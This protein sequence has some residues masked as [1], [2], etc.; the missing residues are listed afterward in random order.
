VVDKR[1]QAGIE[2]VILIG[3]LLVFL[4]PTI[5]YSLNEANNNVKLTQLESSVRR[6]VKAADSVHAIG[7]GTI[8]IITITLP[9]GIQSVLV[10]GTR[11]LMK[12]SM[13]GGISDVHF[14]SNAELTGTLPTTEGTYNIRV[15]SQRS[16][17]VN[18]T[19]RQ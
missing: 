18:I 3:I 6:L 2:Y 7:P 15:E 13:F 9:S 4:I 14:P 1:G 17:K 16:G 10:N 8:E 5:Y 12:V 11:I 19:Q